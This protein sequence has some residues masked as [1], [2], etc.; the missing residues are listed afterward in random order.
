[1]YLL[2]GAPGR[3]SAAPEAILEEIGVP[4]EYVHVDARARQGDDYKRLNP[5]GQVPTLVVGDLAISESAGICAYLCDSHPEVGLAPPIGSRERGAFYQWL[6][7][8]SNTLQPAYMLFIYPQRYCSEPEGAARVAENAAERIRESWQQIEATL[9]QGPFLL[10]AH[11]SACD[12]YL[13][14]LST[15][16]RESIVPLSRFARVCKNIELVSRRPGVQRMIARNA[17]S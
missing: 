8:L 7:F 14:M 9:E 11:P 16:H 5:L 6:F 17:G 2:Y 12:I 4:Y 15:W 10:G 1:M 3:A 13:Y